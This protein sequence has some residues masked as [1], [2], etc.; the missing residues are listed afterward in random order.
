MT[1]AD[2]YVGANVGRT[3]R[4]QPA[5]GATWP[6][7]AFATS[8]SRPSEEPDGVTVATIM[9]LACIDGLIAGAFS[10]GTLQLL[11]GSNASSNTVLLAIVCAAPAWAIAQ[12]VL[13]K[14][15]DSL[16]PRYLRGRLGPLLLAWSEAAA[17][18]LFVIA[19]C[20]VLQ[21]GI[22]IFSSDQAGR[23]L[24]L[25]LT[26]G[27]GLIVSRVIWWSLVLPWFEPVFPRHNVMI[28]GATPTAGKVIE[29]L[30]NDRLRR[31]NLV[32]ILD[33]QPATVRSSFLSI[34]IVGPLDRAVEC[35]R[36]CCIDQ[37]LV[38]SPN[39]DVSR[40]AHMIEQ[41][42]MT[43]AEVRFVFDPDLPPG[44]GQAVSLKDDLIFAR[45][46]GR[47]IAGWAAAVKRAEDLVVSGVA[48]LLLGP[49]LLAIA[50]AIKLDSPGP[51]FFRQ[52]RFGF[53]NQTFE[54]LKFRTM[55]TRMADHHAARQSRRGDPRVTRVGAFLRRHSLDELPQ[56][57]NVFAGSMSVVGPRPHA[58]ATSV[59]GLSLHQLARRYDARHRVKPG[60]TG[61]AQI[62]RCRGELDSVEKLMRRVEYDLEYIE[63]WSPLLDLRILVVTAWRI[64]HDNDAY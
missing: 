21:N 18:L 15:Y 56:L 36:D 11:A 33:D 23:E 27:A 40:T 64:F 49:L 55:Y 45:I 42:S 62:N 22:I 10:Y 8:K 60:I 25:F 47:P 48:L 6:A 1:P 24:M 35:I 28:I 39:A 59:D 31:V 13:H 63:N 38:A 57:F 3:E 58:M 61:W 29:R 34:P 2:G 41:L 46:H 19:L 52:L 12:F 9:A 7:A 44:A 17:S 32:G 30:R 50:I 26:C 53:N 43:P 4:R 54:V 37:V 14:V 51:V 20:L 16:G 5:S